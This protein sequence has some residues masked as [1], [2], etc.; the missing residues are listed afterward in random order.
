MWKTWP[1]FNEIWHQ[2]CLK[3]SI[4]SWNILCCKSASLIAPGIENLKKKKEGIF[5]FLTFC[6]RKPQKYLEYVYACI[7]EFRTSSKNAE[8]FVMPL[9]STISVWNADRFLCYVPPTLYQLEELKMNSRFV[10]ISAA[11]TLRNANCV[12]YM[13]ICHQNTSN[14][15][16]PGRF[17][18]KELSYKILHT[19]R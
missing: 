17:L 14:L 5:F 8:T 6:C 7:Q 10:A 15:L 11:F 9:P 13:C 1:K 19:D 16:K 3:K 18:S 12:C 4:C 2:I